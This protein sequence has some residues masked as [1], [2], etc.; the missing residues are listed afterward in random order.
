MWTAASIELLAARKHFC[1]AVLAL[2]LATCLTGCNPA[3]TVTSPVIA[4]PPAKQ[5][6]V[7]IVLDACR[8]DHMSCYGYT[9][10]TT[11]NIDALAAR[12]TIFREHFAQGFGTIVSVPSY[13]T[14]RY[15]PTASLG[16]G[17]W[18]ESCRIPPPDE[19]LAPAI[20]SANGYATTL[21]SAHIWIT[22]ESRLW[23]AFEKQYFI[24]PDDPRDGYASCDSLLPP[25]RETLAATKDRPF[26]LYI[27]VM[28]THFP[29]RLSAP[30]DQWMD[31]SYS[32]PLIVNGNFVKATGNNFTKDDQKLLNALH[33]GSLLRVDN[34][35]RQVVS[36]LH[37]FHHEDDTLVVIGADHGDALGEDGATAGHP[38]ILTDEIMQVPLIMAGPGIPVSKQIDTLTQNVDILPTLV[39]LS[40]L[41]TPAMFDGK[42]VTPLLRGK[43][44][45]LHD[46]ASARLDT[47][48][49]E[50]P[51]IVVVRNATA[52][53][54]INTASGE[55][56][57]LQLPHRL[58]SETEIGP[59]GH[60]AAGALREIWE[61]ELRPKWEAYLAL[62]RSQPASPFVIGITEAAFAPESAV[63]I[64]SGKE[65][66]AA[67]HDDGKWMLHD[68]KLWSDSFQEDAP[69]MT[70]V[71]SVPDGKYQLAVELYSKQDFFGHP[72]SALNITVESGPVR[73]LITKA[74]PTGYIFHDVG[75]VTVSGGQL[76]IG[77]DEANTTH[78]AYLRSF[79][80]T[81][82]G[83]TNDGRKDPPNEETNERL[84]ALGYL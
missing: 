67:T 83:T 19:I 16:L 26:F 6:V 48:G 33:D 18:Q 75:E 7:W 84:R 4:S 39:D 78:W 76:R 71:L 61:R 40:G 35:V 55:A 68:G 80:F 59:A 53:L 25:I 81:P 45:T 41:D 1:L 8:A 31:K 49:Y 15:F 11:P 14:G 23:Q 50:N 37:E 74:E 73:T 82:V 10:S 44:H 47:N 36:L 13:L 30:Y 5:N 72:A 43:P 56:R 2:V 70:A 24:K 58:G 64:S 27:H 32:S 28:D 79:Q 63:V 29:H 22:P 66:S 21:V 17:K 60:G 42:S 52:K 51:P 77:L 62:P 69:P 9:R 3:P 38:R 46:W 54:A 57:L 12:G 34:F 65:L 20:F